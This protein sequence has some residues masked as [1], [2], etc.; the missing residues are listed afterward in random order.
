MDPHLL[1]GLVN[2]AIRDHNDD[3]EDLCKT[4]DIDQSVLIKRLAEA[5]YDYMPEQRQFR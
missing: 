4:H 2:T 1:V 3:L 5:G